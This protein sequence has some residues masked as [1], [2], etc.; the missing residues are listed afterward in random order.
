M[1]KDFGKIC[2]IKN[3]VKMRPVERKY[4]FSELEVFIYKPLVKAKKFKLKNG[5]HQQTIRT[6]K[7]STL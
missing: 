3:I 2:E 1:V 7:V 6:G 4:L 5:P